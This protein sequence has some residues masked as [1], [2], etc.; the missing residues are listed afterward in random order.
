MRNRIAISLVALVLSACSTF[1]TP[2]CLV[3]HPIVCQDGTVYNIR[4]CS[5]PGTSIVGNEQFKLQIESDIT[6]SDKSCQLE[7][8]SYDN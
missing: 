8:Y 6:V 3:L 2:N 5:T 1:T 4:A 7:K